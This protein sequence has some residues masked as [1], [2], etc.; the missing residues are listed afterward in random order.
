MSQL[1]EVITIIP[2]EP[3]LF[4]GSLRFNLDPLNTCKEGDI[5]SLLK[6]SGIE[7]L[8]LKKKKEDEEKKKELEKLLSAE[9]LAKAQDD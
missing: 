9:E 8:V 6:E 2:Q 1:R 5:L 7:E 4:K 3:T